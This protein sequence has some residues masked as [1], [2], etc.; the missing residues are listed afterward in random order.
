MINLSGQHKIE[1]NQNSICSYFV[2]FAIYQER[3]I[4]EN[5]SNLSGEHKTEEIKAIKVT[6]N[7]RAN[8]LGVSRECTRRI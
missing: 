1:G 5:L 7:W 6:N 2:G 3:I 8:C 4:V